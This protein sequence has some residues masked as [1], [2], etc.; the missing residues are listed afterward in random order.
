MKKGLSTPKDTSHLKLSPKPNMRLDADIALIKED[1]SEEEKA[2]KESDRTPELTKVVYDSPF[3]QFRDLHEKTEH[4]AQTSNDDPLSQV[5]IGEP[6]DAVIH[7]D[8]S[9]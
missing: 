5:V 6:A 3:P 7:F 9:H 8:S 1:K 2:K 4:L